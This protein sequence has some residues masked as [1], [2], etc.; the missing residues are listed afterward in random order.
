MKRTLKRGLKVLEIVKRETMGAFP[1]KKSLASW[2]LVFPGL[3]RVFF[4]LCYT[5]QQQ[6]PCSCSFLT[7][8]FQKG[9]E[10]FELCLCESTSV[11]FSPLTENGQ[12]DVVWGLSQVQRQIYSL[13]KNN[14]IG[15]TEEG[16]LDCMRNQ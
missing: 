16:I 10:T 2:D 12:E 14:V 11:F 9:R 6:N 3:C 4:C 8:F 15:N 5:A 7:A 13:S 1:Q